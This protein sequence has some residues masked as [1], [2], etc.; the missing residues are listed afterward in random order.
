MNDES[1][2]NSLKPGDTS[3]YQVSARLCLTPRSELK[4]YTKPR[5]YY[6]LN[7]V[8]IGLGN[9]LFPPIQ[10]QAITYTKAHILSICLTGTQTCLMKGRP[11]PFGA[12]S[13]IFL[14]N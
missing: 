14:D 8:I 4:S 3:S 12:E 9:G 11:L 5:M 1:W 6:S 10:C 13:K 2:F 7:W